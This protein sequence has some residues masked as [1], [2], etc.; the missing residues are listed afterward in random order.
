MRGEL[1]GAALEQGA[2]VLRLEAADVDA[3]DA[4]AAREPVRRARED[5][6]EHDGGSD[7]SRNE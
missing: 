2:G 4:D 1:R 3:V 7:E 5:E 6:P